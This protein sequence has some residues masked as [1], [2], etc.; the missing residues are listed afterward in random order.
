MSRI[1]AFLRGINLGNRRLTMDEL[2]EAFE[3]LGF[4]GVAT[5]LASGNVVFGDPGA[6]HAA[7]ERRIAA[8]LEEALGYPV[9]TFLRPLAELAGV[10]GDDALEAA[11][12]EGFKP[13]VIFL[14]GEPEAE[15]KTALAAL[16]TTDDR[17]RV[18]GRQV[19]WLRRGRLSDS[20]IGPRDLDAA[21]GGPEHT[22]RTLNTVRGIVRKFAP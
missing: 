5:Y 10:V 12:E 18:L 15:T 7:L 13:H 9:R 3:A 4:E 1:A 22:M 11:E 6:E 16:E 8:G 19:V 21:F 17:F 14:R 20:A 2:R